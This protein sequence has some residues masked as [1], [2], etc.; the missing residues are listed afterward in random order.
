MVGLRPPLSQAGGLQA[1]VEER[2]G[3]GAKKQNSHLLD[4]PRTITMAAPCAG[5]CRQPVQLGSCGR[6]WMCGVGLPKEGK[7][8][9]MGRWGHLRCAQVSLDLEPTP[10]F[11]VS[12]PACL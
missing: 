3:D 10:T 7:E 12:S 6:P 9:V 8:Q 11:S 2:G 5:I 1:S 4:R